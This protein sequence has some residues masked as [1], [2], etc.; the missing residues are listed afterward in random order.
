MIPSLVEPWFLTFNANVEFRPVM[1]SEDLKEAGL[2]ELG[3][4]WG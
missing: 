2:E 4:K 1:N 3:K